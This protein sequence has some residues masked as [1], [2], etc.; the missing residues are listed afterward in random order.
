MKHIVVATATVAALVC[1]ALS[2]APTSEASTP[3]GR[4]TDP[5]LGHASRADAAL[6]DL[7][8]SQ[9]R[10]AARTA[11]VGVDELHAIAADDDTLWM[12]R[13]SDA[14]YVEGAV[15]AAAPAVVAADAPVTALADTF[16]LSSRP[17]ATR[18]VYLDFN[19]QT[20]TGTAW[21]STYGS[22]ITA[23]PF[24][25]SAPADTTYTAAELTQIQTAWAMVAEDYAPF[26]VNVTT[27]DPGDAALLRTSSSDTAY[28]VRVIVT[29]GG[30]IDTTCSCAGVAYVGAFG[31][32]SATGAHQPVWAFSDSSGSSAK[33]LGEV[34]AHEVGHTLG[35]HHDG[36]DDNAYSYGD[37]P[38]APIMGASY[39]QPVTQWSAGTYAGSTNREDDLALIA[40]RLPLIADDH[41]ATPDSATALA[42]GVAT[43]GL[44]S[45]RSD[46]DAFT[47]SA[48]GATS[49]T[50]TTP[51]GYADLDAS[52]TVLDANGRTLAVVD[53]RATR[54]SSVQAAGLD[55]TWHTTL[56]T[57]ATTLTLLVD[58]VGLGDGRTFSDYS[59]YASV[60]AYTITTT[61]TAP[62]AADPLTVA[63]TALGS[64][65]VG[66]SYA[67]SVATARGGTAPYTFT[68]TGLPDGITLSASGALSGVPTTAGTYSVAVTATDSLGATARATSSLTVSG[69]TVTRSLWADPVSVYGEVGRAIDVDLHA[70]G[71]SGDYRWTNRTLPAWISVSPDGH[72]TGTPTTT[73][74]AWGSVTVTSGDESRTI[75]V[76][77]FAARASVPA[78]GQTLQVDGLAVSTR[79]RAAI[80]QQLAP[81]GGTGSYLFRSRG[82]PSGVRLNAR[83]GA[84]T[85]AVARA[86]TYVATV[87]V[88]SGSQTASATLTFVAEWPPLTAADVS[89]R[90]V[91]GRRTS[92]RLR[93][94]HGTGAY[95]W[96]ATALPPG[97]RVSRRGKLI[98]TFTGRIDDV[99]P[100]T[101]TSGGY[102]TT[103]LVHLVVTPPALPGPHASRAAR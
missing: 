14:F 29:S 62:V 24:S 47:I 82:L 55:A 87:T 77:V 93:A 89:V 71:G 23:A 70:T 96:S 1:C 81:V 12:D 94:H 49:V 86:G 13:C 35:L 17:S 16:S 44:I 100:V 79:T 59:D 15:P 26:D 75:S 3:P 95:A 52:L 65:T 21:N 69:A 54:L 98:A 101:V 18:T 9:Q 67:A 8:A 33:G 6:D 103:V 32:V 48:S 40:S 51:S 83:T 37:D 39:Y 74:S 19:G 46:A 61:T 84:I 66:A 10:A 25:L 63:P 2:T 42:S 56:P 4:C 11:E 28:G 38:W 20:V 7:S 97:A 43:D 36:N 53:P 80:A 27:Q 50:V 72:L 90:T 60:G 73:R 92:V 41:G 78:E 99:Y 57:S 68:A 85:G 91:T 34:I 64:A 45:T 31:E 58:G 88:T 5:V 102:R 76:R 30:P 22:T